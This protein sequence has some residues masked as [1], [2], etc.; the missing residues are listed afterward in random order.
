MKVLVWLVALSLIIEV[1]S[2]SGFIST[3]I[4][5]PSQYLTTALPDHFRDYTSSFLEPMPPLHEF[6]KAHNPLRGKREIG[7]G[8]GIFV[9]SNGVILTNAHVVDQCDQIFVSNSLGVTEAKILEK[10]NQVDLASLG[11][12]S[13]R[14]LNDGKP[15]F[16][17][18]DPVPGSQVYIFGYPLGQKLTPEGAFTQGVISATETTRGEAFF[19]HTAEIQPGSSGSGMFDE[20]GN[21]VGITVGSD[22]TFN[23]ALMMGVIPQNLNYGINASGIFWSG[24]YLEKDNQ[25]DSILNIFHRSFNVDTMVIAERLKQITVQVHC[26]ANKPSRNDKANKPSKNDQAIL[27]LASFYRVSV[28]NL[29]R[30]TRIAGGKGEEYERHCSHYYGSHELC[31]IGLLYALPYKD[32]L[33]R[34][35]K[36]QACDSSLSPKELQSCRRVAI[37]NQIV[38]VEGDY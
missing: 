36:F 31:F 32:A 5:T 38:F 23:S 19:S 17:I 35:K 30:A 12:G 9:R 10:S 2:R 29:I 26:I 1:L 37:T 18:S 21:L 33:I 11:L 13:T 16:R 8:T 28:E 34:L 3:S 15:L 7:T 4:T 27:D 20:L 25:R 14:R 24:V 6:S 22:S